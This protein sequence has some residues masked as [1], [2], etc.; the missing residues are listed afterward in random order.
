[1]ETTLK[2]TI[3]LQKLSKISKRKKIK[4]KI[5]RASLKSYK[6]VSANNME[7]LFKF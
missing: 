1:M 6:E 4:F 5:C 7:E 3:K 2:I